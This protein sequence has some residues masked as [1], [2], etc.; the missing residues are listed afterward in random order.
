MTTEAGRDR[1]RDLAF[2]EALLGLSRVAAT[3]STRLRA[4]H[5]DERELGHQAAD[6]AETP[7]ALP[8]VGP[9]LGPRQL[10]V[11]EVEGLESELGLSAADVA[12][13]AAL[14]APN[15]TVALK[16]LAELGYLVQV[17]GQR[18]ARWRRI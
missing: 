5:A 17:D 12:D 16:R 3:L 15:A 7:P 1:A 9:R 6:S 2:A 13:A 10:R 18:P 4:V 8:T 14:M 11:L